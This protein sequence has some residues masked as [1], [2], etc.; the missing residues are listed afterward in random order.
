MKLFDKIKKLIPIRDA[1]LLKYIPKMDILDWCLNIFCNYI[2]S[3]G[4]IPTATTP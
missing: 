3:I 2:Y 4:L 1:A